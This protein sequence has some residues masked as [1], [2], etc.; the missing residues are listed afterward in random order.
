MDYLWPWLTPGLSGQSTPGAI[1]V[2]EFRAPTLA[3]ENL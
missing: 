3:L 1:E 2:E